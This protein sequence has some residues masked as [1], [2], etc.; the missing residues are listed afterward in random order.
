MRNICF[1]VPRV[2]LSGRICVVR[3]AKVLFTT[4]KVGEIN[5]SF[6]GFGRSVWGCSLLQV[7]GLW[8]LPADMLTSY[9]SERCSRLNYDVVRWE[10]AMP[11]VT[12]IV[13]SPN[14]LW[15]KYQAGGSVLDV[16]YRNIKRYEKRLVCD[17]ATLMSDHHGRNANAIA[18]IPNR[19]F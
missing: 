17:V 2:D 10:T 12:I 3:D 16:L 14:Y 8:Y 11:C 6:Y 9:F 7:S 5:Y 4:S 13:L 19:S 18:S 15:G 1:K